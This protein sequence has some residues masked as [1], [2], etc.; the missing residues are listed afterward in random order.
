M[1]ELTVNTLLKKVSNFIGTFPLD[2]LPVHIP[3]NSGLIANTHTSDKPGEHWVAIFKDG[4]G[5]CE[6]FDSY[7]LPPLHLEF[8]DFIARNTSFNFNWNRQLLQ[9]IECVTC[10]YYCVEYIKLRCKGL[11][12][13]DVLSLFTKNPYINDIIIRNKISKYALDKL[14]FK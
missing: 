9:C 4:L 14:K 3:K 12:L 11:K 7:G 6:Y 8:F 13:F 10:G 1:D 2:Q 5:C